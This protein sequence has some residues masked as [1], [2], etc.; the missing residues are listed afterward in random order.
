MQSLISTS[1]IVAS[2]LLK[3]GLA[4]LEFIVIVCELTPTIPGIS[5]PKSLMFYTAK[6]TPAAGFAAYPASAA[7]EILLENLNF[8]LGRDKSL[9]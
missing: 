8:F 9:A 5:A 3:Y 6:A 7:V 4:S 2:L 1:R